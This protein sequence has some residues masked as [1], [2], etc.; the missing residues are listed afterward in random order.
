MAR[1]RAPPRVRG[2][3]GGENRDTPSG[4]P[5]MSRRTGQGGLRNP[6]RGNPNV[7][8]CAVCGRTDVPQR[9]GEAGL[10]FHYAPP[11]CELPCAGGPVGTRE[12]RPDGVHP[13]NCA[14]QTGT[15]RPGEPA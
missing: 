10:A 13:G 4:L 3:P 2:L 8:R 5:A 15:S 7:G 1:L 9:A 14:C 11:P 6:P 12:D